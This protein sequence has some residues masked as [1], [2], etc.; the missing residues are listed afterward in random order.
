MIPFNGSASVGTPIAQMARLRSLLY[1][2]TTAITV[3]VAMTRINC[4]KTKQYY[5]N[6]ITFY[7][8]KFFQPRG[9]KT[10]NG[11]CMT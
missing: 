9:L 10:I 3:K 2:K 1:A 4:N 11:K 7:T 6:S 5:N 8:F